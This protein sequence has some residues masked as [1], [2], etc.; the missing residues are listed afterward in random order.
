MAD[1]IYVVEKIL[2]KKI[3][4]NGQIEYFIKWF[5]YD[6]E[7]ATWEPEENVF[8]KD[9]I[10]QY[11]RNLTLND[12]QK[13]VIDECREILSQICNEIDNLNETVSSTLP[14]VTTNTDEQQMIYYTPRSDVSMC[15]TTDYSE[16]IDENII[17]D[18]SSQHNHLQ[19]TNRIDEL[20]NDS[21][22]ENGELNAICNSHEVTN[23]SNH[24]PKRTS[25]VS[26]NRKKKFRSDSIEYQTNIVDENANDLHNPQ[27][28]DIEN[29]TIDYRSLEP[30]RIVS[31]TRSRTS[32]HEL[33]FLLKCTRCPTKL[34]FISN[35]KAKELVPDLLIDFYERHINW[36][37]D[38][39]STKQRTQ[40][41]KS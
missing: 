32:T 9:L 31:I 28:E 1:D 16:T 11:E 41:R 27:Q 12:I 37:I 35:E 18:V 2:N 7:D 21:F 33:E 30:E 26:L 25:T 24:R 5:G 22:I 29:N 8:C 14:L 13:N 23:E 38:R 40:G 20:E 6:E 10:E 4:D 34:Y 36:F 17:P 39:P 15:A 19:S 3:L